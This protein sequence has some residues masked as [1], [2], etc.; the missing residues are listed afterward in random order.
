MRSK[1]NGMFKTLLIVGFLLLILWH[2]GAGL[3]YML[4]D[5]S[6]S[7][8]TVNSLTW[9]VGLSILLVL[10]LVLGIHMG[11]IK[12]HDVGQSAG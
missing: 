4:V 8:R 7:K 6:S 9:R 3:Y 5:K 1:Q 2:L 11:W 12:P 10:V